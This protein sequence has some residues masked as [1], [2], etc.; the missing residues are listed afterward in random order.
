MLFHFPKCD[1]GLWLAPS[2]W[3]QLCRGKPLT[4]PHFFKHSKKKKKKK[5]LW[6]AACLHRKWISFN[7]KLI[8]H[9]AS[10]LGLC[11]WTEPPSRLPWF[12]P[13]YGASVWLWVW[14]GQDISF[15][16]PNCCNSSKGWQN[17][18]W[19][20]W[21]SPLHTN[22]SSLFQT[23]WLGH[24]L[25]GWKK[26]KRER[27]KERRTWVRHCMHTYWRR[28][29]HGLVLKD[30][31]MASRL[32][33]FNIQTSDWRLLLSWSCESQLCQRITFLIPS[34]S[35]KRKERESQKAISSRHFSVSIHH[36]VMIS[37]FL[38]SHWCPTMNVWLMGTQSHFSYFR[39]QETTWTEKKIPNT[40]STYC[41]NTSVLPILGK[42]CYVEQLIRKCLCDLFWCTHPE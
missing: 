35:L 32:D 1:C 39:R 9:T 42:Q 23:S 29:I 37:S 10:W 21:L 33:R 13:E 25:E 6:P 15:T 11:V 41:T 27:E 14:F 18:C 36:C 3:L 24:P 7:A 34:A 40:K 20:W 28:N 12:H 31:S 30:F 16:R 8:S 26:E 38:L 19:F 17:L 4:Q 2:H 22:K 5:S